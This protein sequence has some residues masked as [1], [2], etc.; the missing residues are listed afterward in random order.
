[1]DKN[2]KPKRVMILDKIID[3]LSSYNLLN[4]LIP[5][6][7]FC[8]LLQHICVVDILSNSIVENLFIYYFVGM[9][10]S[11]IGSIVIEPFVRKTG[12]VIYADYGDYIMASKT[13][14]KIDIL[15]ET[16][17]LYRTIVAGAFLI[18]VTKLYIIAEQNIALLSYAT[19]YILALS[20]LIMFLLS[21]RKQTGYIRKRVEKVTRDKQQEDKP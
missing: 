17:N 21:Y 9:V 13:D 19:P 14:S 12:I 1:M 10:V 18:I 8:Y 7:I 20:L 15:L 11:R 6:S 2:I 16:N 4:N 5:G 3:K